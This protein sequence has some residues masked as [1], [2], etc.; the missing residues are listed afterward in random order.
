MQYAGESC[1]VAGCDKLIFLAVC[2][3]YQKM[4][5]KVKP[6]DGR[7]ADHDSY[8]VFAAR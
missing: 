6:N 2:S 8:T 5:L 4:G 1:S 3:N 7:G